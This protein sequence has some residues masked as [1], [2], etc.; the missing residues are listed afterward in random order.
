MMKAGKPVFLSLIVL[1][2]VLAALIPRGDSH[3][4]KVLQLTGMIEGLKQYHYQPREIDDV[5]SAMVFRQY[6]ENLDGSKRF[7]TL[8][9]IEAL[10]IHEKQIDDQINNKTF[11][12]YDDAADRYKKAIARSSD[13]YAEIL[14]KPFDFTVNE[15]IETDAEK[16]DWAASEDQLRDRWRRQLKY[17]VLYRIYDRMDEEPEL[18]YEDGEIPSQQLE[19]PD[20]PEETK[21]FEELEAEARKAVHDRYEEWFKRMKKTKSSEYFSEYLSSIAGIFDPHTQFFEPVDKAN[22]DISMSNKLEGIGARLQTEKDETKVVS[23]IP[24]GPAWKQKELEVNDIIL[25]VAQGA[26]EAVVVTGMNINEVVS[27]IRG[28]KGTEVRLTVRK[29]DG[30]NKVISIIREEVLLDEGLAK[31]MIISEPGK[32]ERLGYIR[33]PRFYADFESKDGRSC[34]V[35]MAKEIDKLKNERV[36]G[37]IVDLRSNGGGSLRDVVTMSGYFIEKGPIVQVRSRGGKASLH[38]DRD[39]SVLWD[40]PLIVMVNEFSASAS[41]IMAAA[42]Q[43]YSRAVIVGSPSTYG[44]GTVQRF[45]DLD[46]A[47]SG[48]NIHKPLGEVK[49]TIQ[50]FYR[51]NGGSTQLKGVIPDI[52]L[53]DNYSLLNIGEKEYKFALPFSEIPAVPFDQKVYRVDGQLNDLRSMSKARVDQAAHFQLVSENAARFKRQRDQSAYTLHMEQ[54]REMVR[55]R[56]AEAD[57]YKDIY[58]A[59][60]ALQVINPAQDLAY[61]RADSSRIARNDDFISGVRKDFH[62]QETM[63]IMR[64]MIRLDRQVARNRK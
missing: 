32:P 21:S 63:E 56:K 9:D 2:A 10:Q 24:G 64:D 44:K 23:I 54:Y 58:P 45:F 17:E 37:I 11:A 42:L 49:L 18:P 15:E 47:I 41:E 48:N 1:V 39:P 20:E 8:K 52:I 7:F 43:D 36:S 51:I 28:K 57:R 40:G 59:N 50:N 5:F 30:S 26:E 33:L 3:D 6:L 34:A 38:D 13:W 12:F 60:E 35:D 31:S 29:V 53:P 19:T 4:K 27:L 14:D 16:L 55:K 61:I 25:K 62:L 46:N 22:F